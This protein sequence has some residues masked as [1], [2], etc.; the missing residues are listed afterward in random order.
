MSHPTTSPRYRA[1]SRQ[2][3]AAS[4]ASPATTE[5]WWS[6]IRRAPSTPSRVTWSWSTNRWASSSAGSSWWNPRG[7]R[8]WWESAWTIARR[9]RAHR[10]TSSHRQETSRRRSPTRAS[11][12][13]PRPRSRLPWSRR[14]PL[15]WQ[16]RC[17]A[18]AE[19]APYGAPPATARR[20][21]CG[22]GDRAP[23]RETERSQAR[24]E[25]DQGGS[26]EDPAVPEPAGPT[27]DPRP[28][29][30]WCRLDR[31]RARPLGL[32]EDRPHR[33]RRQRVCGRSRP[34]V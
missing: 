18:T 2:R 24:S 31:R 9:R 19:T 20:C 6:W 13:R 3:S 1:S 29:P 26:E 7:W 22:R 12:P 21:R 27:R 34:A 15:R 28:E 17:C 33:R 30:R 25:G 32:R 11:S 16:G 23:L 10:G 4:T 8:A 14:T 5:S